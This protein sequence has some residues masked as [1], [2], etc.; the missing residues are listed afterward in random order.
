MTINESWRAEAGMNAVFAKVCCISVGVIVKAEDGLKIR[1]KAFAGKDEGELLKAVAPI[2][3]KAEYI[4]GHNGKRFDFPF[5]SRRYLINGLPVPSIL[6]TMGLKPWEVRSFDTLEM[7]Q[8]GDMKNFTSLDA[9][10]LAFDLPSPKDDVTG[11]DVAPLYYDA[12]DLDRIGQ[13]C[14]KDVVTLIN[15]YL[16]IIGNQIIDDVVVVE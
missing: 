10:A 14:N 12:D 15:V 11:A 6:Q 13:Y 5:L 9:L 1:V 3:G 7:W 16:R 4:C 8:F 2:F